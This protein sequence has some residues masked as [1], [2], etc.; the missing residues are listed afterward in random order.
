MEL[1]IDTYEVSQGLSEMEK[2][3]VENVFLDQEGIVWA[4]IDGEVLELDGLL[5]DSLAEILEWLEEAYHIK[6]GESID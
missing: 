3:L 2:P 1:H 5:T 6:A 4:T